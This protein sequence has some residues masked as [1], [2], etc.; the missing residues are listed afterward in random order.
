VTDSL[1]TGQRSLGDPDETF[2][3]W[4]PIVDGCPATSTDEVQYPLEVTYEYDAVDPALFDQPPLPGLDRW[5]PLLPP[6]ADGV[7]LGAG[8][9]RLVAA[10]DLAETVGFD[11]ALHLK[12]ESA[13][14]TWSHKD[15]L[16][17]PTVGAAVARDAPGVVVSSTGNHGASV[18]AHAAR[19]GLP[20]VVFTSRDLPDS[21]A[22]FLDA[23]GAAVAKVPRERRWECMRRVRDELGYV[24][25]SN[26]TPT[27]TGHPF[28]PE[29]Y[30]T[31]AY[32]IHAQLDGVPGSV[33]VPTG[34]AELLY[35]VWKG[36]RELRELG[37]VDRAPEMVACEPAARAP[38][39]AALER[40][41]PAVTVDA[42][43][44]DASSIGVTVNGYRGVRAVRESGGRA[45]ALSD[46]AIERAQERLAAVGYWQE[47][48]GAAGLAG[49]AAAVAADDPLPGP[50]VAV[51]CSSGFKDPRGDVSVPE[52]DPDA[53]VA[54]LAAEY[55]LGA[56][57]GD[58]GA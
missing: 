11:G 26:L 34:Y 36:F 42:A 51:C 30:K 35:G 25:T 49:L 10:P 1:A 44:T 41:A 47:L 22:R 5:A 54:D 4:P 40:D 7:D 46:A 55:G 37:I 48:S 8:G 57:D 45:H 17:A 14:P 39:S 12:D 56:A 6:L 27:H 16:A 29:G 19:A 32:E 13:N 31:I 53:V 21:M 58:A 43:P 23:Y 28:G 9:T 52:L 3:L 20:C 50:A 24:P 33:L 2:P 18:A 15:R 38:L